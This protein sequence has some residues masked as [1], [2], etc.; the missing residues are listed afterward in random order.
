MAEELEEK[1]ESRQQRGPETRLEEGGNIHHNLFS[2]VQGQKAKV[3]LA[4]MRR[5]AKRR[6]SPMAIPLRRLWPRKP[7]Q[8]SHRV[9]DSAAG[10]AIDKHTGN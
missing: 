2:P 5:E 8:P 7:V 6:G 9:C 4:Q 1:K 3:H 10:A